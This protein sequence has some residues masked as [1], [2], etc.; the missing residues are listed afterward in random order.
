MNLGIRL[1][2][3]LAAAG[4]AWTLVEV[5]DAPA[6][7][8]PPCLPSEED[9][10]RVRAIM[11]AAIDAAFKDQIM[12]LF[13]VWMKDA[14]DQPTRAATGARNAVRAYVGSRRTV[15]DWQPEICK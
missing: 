12:H 5:M 7:L 15:S 11:L 2:I 1:V 14:K 4:V 10:E 8:P 3:G 6:Q 9:R 13:E